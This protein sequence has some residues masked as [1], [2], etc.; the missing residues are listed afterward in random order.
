VLDPAAPARATRREWPA[1][2]TPSTS[3]DR[4]TESAL[5]VAADLVFGTIFGSLSYVERN[6]GSPQVA[7]GIGVAAVPLLISAVYG[8]V[9]VSRCRSYKSLFR[10][11]VTG[12]HL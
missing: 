9:T 5:P 6:S 8:A 12:E 4:C 1:Q 7:F 3:E 11:S 2:V 10:D